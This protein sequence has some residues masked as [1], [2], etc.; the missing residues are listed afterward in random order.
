[1]RFCLSPVLSPSLRVCTCVGLL[2]FRG[3]LGLC[4]GEAGAG[5]FGNPKKEE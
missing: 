3:V 2:Q 5:V 1:M 4:E